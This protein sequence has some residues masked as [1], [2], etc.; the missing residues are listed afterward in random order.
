MLEN[1]NLSTLLMSAY[2]AIT[3]LAAIIIDA[4]F[5]EKIT[6]TVSIILIC[7]AWPIALVIIIVCAIYKVISWP[8]RKIFR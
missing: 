4:I 8:F 1:L 7:L 3:I 2:F 6:K 5:G